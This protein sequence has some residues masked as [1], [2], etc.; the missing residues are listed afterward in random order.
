MA[1]GHQQRQAEAAEQPL[2]GPFPVA[3]GFVHLQQLACERQRPR[4]QA[5]GLAQLVAQRDVVG[6]DVVAPG[7][8]AGDL[9]EQLPVGAS[10]FGHGDFILDLAVLQ[11][12]FPVLGQLLHAGQALPLC[13]KV[14]GAA[15]AQQACGACQFVV[16]VGLGLAP[17][18]LVLLVG[19]LLGQLLQ[20]VA[21]VVRHAAAQLALQGLLGRA[22]ALQAL[23]PPVMALPL[24]I[25]V[26]NAF[27]QQ[28]QLVL[29]KPGL[30][31]IAA[32]PQALAVCSLRIVAPAILHQ[33]SEQFHLLVRFEHGGMGAAQV[34]EVADQCRNG[35]CH[36]E[37]LEHV[38]AHEPRQI[39]HG[40]HRDG[41]MKKLQRLLVVDAKAP[42]KPGAVGRK[43]LVQR[44]ALGAQLLAQGTDVAAKVGKIAGDG[45]RALGAHVKARRLAVR[46]LHPE[47]LRQCHRVP[48]GGVVEHPED[49]GIRA[50]VAQRDRLGAAA[51]LV[52][53]GLVVAQHVGPQG[54]LFALCASGLVVGDALRRDQQ[55][56]DGVH[57]RRFA[58]AN[59]SSEQ[60][61]LAA[62]VQA[63]DV[64]VEGAPVE[65]LEPLQPN[66][67]RHV[68]DLLCAVLR[69]QV[70]HRG[71][72][73]FAWGRLPA[74]PGRQPGARRIHPATAHPRRP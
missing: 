26:G 5:Q 23:N 52:A 65:D 8:Q 69:V 61:V 59:V 6:R 51:G 40:L 11:G 55:R 33:G 71:P 43:A 48:I 54:P 53:L 49:D 31:R 57:Q 13:Q 63:P 64:A 2:C 32:F 44:G 38:A 19:D 20:P 22:L 72:L 34:I 30:E 14:G 73:P 10:P 1:L 7:L 15:H 4:W 58:G 47:H 62:G 21:A 24:V 9:A 67:W 39:A 70:I 46:L 27:F 3:L 41:L 17:L 74:A 37:W 35:R 45:Q 18:R 66:A 60:G 29:G 50:G 42:A 28:H 68:A 36:V 25:E 56:G 16:A 12:R